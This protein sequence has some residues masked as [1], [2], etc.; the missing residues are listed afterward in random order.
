MDRMN[1]DLRCA[2]ESGAGTTTKTAASVV[3]L[4]CEDSCDMVTTNYTNLHELAVA[5]FEGTV[6]LACTSHA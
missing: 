4:G 5:R 3:Q 1:A 6:A 2:S